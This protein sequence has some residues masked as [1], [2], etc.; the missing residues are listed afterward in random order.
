M[1]KDGLFDTEL[2]RWPCII[3]ESINFVLE[4]IRLSS[5]WYSPESVLGKKNDSLLVDKEKLLICR[6]NGTLEKLSS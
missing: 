3:N 5:E 1:S 4:D 6:S 2:I